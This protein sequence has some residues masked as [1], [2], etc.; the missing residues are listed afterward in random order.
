M[1]KIDAKD[2]KILYE[3]DV[4]SRQSLAQIGKKVKLPKTV[5]H[6][7]IHSLIERGILKDNYA[8]INYTKLGLI[9]FKLYFKFHSLSPKKEQ[10]IIDYLK[11]KR[12]LV[13][14]ASC[15][16]KWDIAATFIAKEVMD[17][18]DILK[19]IT[20]DYGKY[21]LENVV[22]I[23]SFSPFYSRVYLNPSRTKQEFIYISK[24]NRIELDATDQKIVTALSKDA[25]SAILKISSSLNLSRDVVSYRIKKLEKAGVI[26][27]YRWLFDHEKVGFRFYKLILRLHNFSKTEELR[28]LEHCKMNQYIVQYMRLFGGWD[29]EIEFEID[30][31][32]KMFE[33]INEI[34]E[35][36]D[37]IIRDYEVLHVY[38][39]H[40]LNMY[41]L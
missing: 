14:A 29:V 40:K 3:L 9:Q 2:K 24:T 12:N 41:P 30:D 22:V 36:F 23:C 37:N 5:V 7:R 20:N 4:N 1:E 8:V 11:M 18:D 16:S 13:W 15:R 25:R 33:Y 27:T 21:L 39:E 32:D 6:H 17:F 38:S 26:L 19:E 31:E 34:R 10:E 28:L 35:K